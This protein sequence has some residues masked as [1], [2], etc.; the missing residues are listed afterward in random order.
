MATMT[1]VEN[2]MQGLSK[3]LISR[4]QTGFAALFIFGLIN[5]GE[6]IADEGKSIK[7]L[8]DEAADTC[9]QDTDCM[10]GLFVRAVFGETDES[11]DRSAPLFKWSGPVRIAA[12]VGSQTAD[13]IEQTTGELLKTM[14]HLAAIAG[15]DLGPTQGTADEVVNFIL[16]ISGDFAQD[17]EAAFAPLLS[18]V[19]AGRSALYDNLASETAPV[20]NDHLIVERGG[21]ISGG[22]ALTEGNIEAADFNRCVYRVVLNGLGLRHDLPDDVD[23][24]LNPDSERQAWTSVDFMLLK[25]LSDPAVVTGMSQEALADVFPQI[26]QRAIRPSS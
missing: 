8:S 21:S 7:L 13:D 11:D 24:V 1:Y 16:L 2:I 3:P 22:V 19:F 18:D 12:F 20:C 5:A 15:S 14:H 9:I 10:H 4:S 26:H 6:A 25:I 17:R 23:S